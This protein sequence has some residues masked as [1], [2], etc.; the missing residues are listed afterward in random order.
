MR[1]KA[2][3]G[4]SVVMIVLMVAGT[5]NAA[6]PPPTS[7]VYQVEASIGES[8]GS[9]LLHDGSSSYA[10]NDSVAY[11]YNS[12]TSERADFMQFFPWR[13]RTFSI[14]TSLVNNGTAVLCDGFSRISA[15]SAKTPQWFENLDADGKSL[16]GDASITCS[17][18]NAGK[19]GFGVFYPDTSPDQVLDLTTECVAFTRNA[20]NSY[21]FSAAADS[22]TSPCQA[23]IYSFT[24]PQGKDWREY[25]F[26]GYSSAPFQVTTV[27]DA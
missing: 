14:Q 7:E 11:I 27:F 23:A 16:L 2:L 15:H 18:D 4:V 20:A 17:T 3:V 12:L 25:T 5:G 8:T 22:P 26:L 1:A 6:P 21:T 13:K 24:D 10:G 19:N 9:V